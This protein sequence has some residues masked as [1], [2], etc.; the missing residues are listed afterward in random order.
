MTEDIDI[1]PLLAGSGNDSKLAI[2]IWNEAIE[3]AAI[4]AKRYLN[5]VGYKGVKT[6]AAIRELKK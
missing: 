1:R 2:R 3:A 6:E 4:E 5:S